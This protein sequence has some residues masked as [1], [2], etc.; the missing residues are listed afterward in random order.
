MT[1]ALFADQEEWM[2]KAIGQPEKQQA[3]QSL[4]PDRIFVEAANIAG[5]QQWAAQRGLPSA[6][7]NTCLANQA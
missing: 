5:L 6:Q 7:A 3:L 4:P 2:G 1:R